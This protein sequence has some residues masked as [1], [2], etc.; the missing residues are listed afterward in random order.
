MRPLTILFA[1][2]LADATLPFA[3]AAT[4]ERIFSDGTI[5]IEHD[6]DRN[7]ELD[8]YMCV[9][10]R[11]IEVACGLVVDTAERSA[12]V[13]LD[14]QT[15]DIAE[16]DVVQL[17]TRPVFESG[18]NNSGNLS[19]EAR[20]I[21]LVRY[22]RDQLKKKRNHYPQDMEVFEELPVKYDASFTTFG[23]VPIARSTAKTSYRFVF[24][25]AISF[26]TALSMHYSIAIMGGYSVFGESNLLD[27]TF[28]GLLTVNYYSH[29]PFDGW[30]AQLGGGVVW[31]TDPTIH[32]L[33]FTF[34]YHVATRG[35]VSLGIAVGGQYF[36]QQLSKIDP[37]IK[38]TAVI[39]PVAQLKMGVSF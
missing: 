8:D 29:R 11:Q 14:H 24:I 37:S 19:G 20:R 3:R 32:T 34:G 23:L 33:V 16:G 36:F 12:L 27:K 21:E 15:E 17:S 26:Q 1:L 39:Y 22:H 25:P 18:E 2:L 10:H 28:E 31:N 4:V 30:W 35:S 9:T 13:K 5:L 6:A 38:D 7:W